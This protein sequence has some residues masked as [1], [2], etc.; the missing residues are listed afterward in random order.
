MSP[1]GIRDLWERLIESNPKITGVI[2]EVDGD[3]ELPTSY[4]GTAIDGTDVP[5]SND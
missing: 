1:Q 5:I 2:V 4:S 3:C